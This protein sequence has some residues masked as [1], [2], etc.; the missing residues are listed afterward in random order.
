MIDYVNL[1]ALTR[2]L[3]KLKTIFSAKEHTHT[4]SSITDLSSCNLST[5]DDGNGNVTLMWSS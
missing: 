2:F 4:K 3:E 5:T 1:A